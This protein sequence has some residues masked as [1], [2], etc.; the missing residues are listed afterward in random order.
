[1]HTSSSMLV[2]FIKNTPLAF[3][4]HLQPCREDVYQYIINSEFLN[5]AVMSACSRV[6]GLHMWQ[7]FTLG[8]TAAMHMCDEAA[9]PRLPV[10]H[11]ARRSAASGYEQLRP[12]QELAAWPRALLLSLLCQA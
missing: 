1:M 6:C 3:S 2:H 9:P 10:C 7:G 12:L 5:Y 4:I 8:F 11:Q